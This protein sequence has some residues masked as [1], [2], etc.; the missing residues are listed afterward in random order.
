MSRS[1]SG[2]PRA[3]DFAPWRTAIAADPA[4]TPDYVRKLEKAAKEVGERGIEVGIAAQQHYP[5]PKPLLFTRRLTPWAG[6]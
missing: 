2:L 3:G 5:L 1:L 4:W 6:G